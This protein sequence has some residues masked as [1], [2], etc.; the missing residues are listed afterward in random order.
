MHFIAF[1]CAKYEI[2]DDDAANDF[3]FMGKRVKEKEV[4]L[5]MGERP[6]CCANVAAA[7]AATSSSLVG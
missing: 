3:I 1:F 7:A 5:R 6:G 4:E 2:N